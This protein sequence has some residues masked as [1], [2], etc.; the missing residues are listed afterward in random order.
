M[1]VLIA[2]KVKDG[3]EWLPRFITQVEQLEGD[4]EKIVV[5]YAESKDKS[6][7]YLK[8]WQDISRH[9]VEIYADPYLP[10]DERHGALLT[11]VKQDIQKILIESK[12][13]WYL[14]LDCDL[15]ELPSNLIPKLMYQDKDIIAAM[16]WTEG[17]DIPTFFDTLIF[18]E[19][20]CRFF[21]FNPPGM[22]ETEPFEVDSMSTC[23]LAK[24][25]VEL[26]GVYKN[27]YPHVPFCH[28][29]KEKGYKIW[30][31]P[32]VHTFHIDLEAMGIM[33]QPL[34][35][36]LSMS[37]YIDNNDN[38]Y[39]PEQVGAQDHHMR[40]L[41]YKADLLRKKENY[42]EVARALE[43]LDR[44]RPLLTASYKVHPELYEF[45][46]LSIASIYPWVD[47]IDI[48]IGPI[49]R[50]KEGY[51]KG[52][53]PIVADPEKK[54]RWIDGVWDSKEAIQK[55]L[56]D[57]CTSKW[58][59]FIDGDELVS[60]MDVVRSWCE[61]NRI[62]GMIY[63]RPKRMYNFF[64]DFKHI[65]FSLNPVSPWAQFGMPHPFLI[66]RDIVGLN[67]G[68]FHTMP[69]DGFGRLITADDPTQRGVKDVLDDVEIFHFGNAL[70]LDKI[71]SKR[72]YY[73][74]R[75]DVVV[76]EDQILD[77][78][79]TPDMVIDEFKD[80]PVGV[81]NILQSHPDYDRTK[82]EIT[83]RAPHFEFKVVR[84]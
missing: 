82:I 2:T 38:Q 36:G 65:A 31:H 83:K 71:E 56:L 20:E 49:K 17:R 77:G 30:V 45:L 67:F 70:G 9:K 29:L 6:F 62:K 7:M 40:I 27:P 34:P 11:R 26:A 76:Y 51:S 68:M 12:A 57:V 25:E 10:H 33:H 46:P 59:L 24:R 79:L 81:R 64:V 74:K 44:Q 41:Q 69:A 80:F 1:S 37:T 22:G 54:I 3:A 63:G 78:V 21:P 32:D 48:V 61:K 58:M 15:V 47:K 19:R 55:K 5:M 50:R 18:R 73:K 28:D 60:G 23:Y 13:E 52:K 16:V 72:D 8:H 35:V 39:S 42:H 84:Q 66:H 75:G 43:R 4:I 53:I 14:N